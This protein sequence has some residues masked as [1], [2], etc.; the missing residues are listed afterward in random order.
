[1]TLITNWNS[2]GNFSDWM[3]NRIQFCKT[4]ICLNLTHPG[5]CTHNPDCPS[6]VGSFH[7]SLSVL[8][9]HHNNC[10]LS[11]FT[12][13]SFVR[14]KSNC[15]LFLPCWFRSQASARLTWSQ[16]LNTLVRK[17]SYAKQAQCHSL[18]F[19]GEQFCREGSKEAVTEAQEDCQSILN[20]AFT[21]FTPPQYLTIWTS[22]KFPE[23]Q[24]SY[25]NSFFL[26]IFQEMV[27]LRK[28]ENSLDR[29]QYVASGLQ[30]W[31]SI[32][33]NLHITV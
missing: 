2:A 21:C 33:L 22:L 17:G 26:A 23:I 7:E 12:Q 5:T 29:K 4:D 24:P 19:W 31:A 13:S 32:K 11:L 16:S 25:H 30:G 3:S 20:V 9:G 10:R 6:Q 18:R 15:T 1:M 14:I 27:C 8:T 28:Q